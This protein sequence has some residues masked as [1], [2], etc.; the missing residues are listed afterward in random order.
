MLTPPT[1]VPTRRMEVEE[2]GEGPYCFSPVAIPGDRARRGK[3]EC[4]EVK[5]CPWYSVATAPS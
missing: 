5:G 2:R 3:K 4:M 1:G